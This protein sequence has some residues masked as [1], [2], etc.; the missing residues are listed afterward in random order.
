MT[1]HQQRV[2]PDLNHERLGDA[3]MHTLHACEEDQ[4]G[5]QAGYFLEVLRYGIHAAVERVAR[6]EV[7][8]DLPGAERGRLERFGQAHG[9]DRGA[10][11]PDV[12]TED[13]K[14]T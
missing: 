10:F 3:A 2:R 4:V 9:V 5:F 13:R 8:E 6:G 1:A 11:A 7:R 14:S 12:V